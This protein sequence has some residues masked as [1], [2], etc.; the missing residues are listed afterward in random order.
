MIVIPAIDI[1]DG[2]VVRLLR[3]DFS[4]KTV[5][6]QDPV[7]TAVNWQ[8]AGAKYIHVVDL[9]GA[10]EGNPK[11]FDIVRQIAQVVRVPIQLGGGV[12]LKEDVDMVLSGGVS[13]V[14]VSTRVI[15]DEKFLQDIIKDYADKIAISIDSKGGFVSA[16]GWK[17][18]ASIKILDFAKRL[19][20]LGAKLIICTDVERDGTLQGPNI[21]LIKE[22]LQ[23]TTT[24][25]IISSGGISSIDDLIALKNIDAKRI[26]GAIVG[27]ALYEGKFRLEDAIAALC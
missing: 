22:I 15:Y 14:I 4:I 2:K 3:G 13:R 23:A 7:G 9:D 21:E 17:T 26:Y 11:N 25:N 6:S 8:R 20:K 24:I 18:T 27:K 10:L 12:R 19:E 1:K 5:Y 16:E